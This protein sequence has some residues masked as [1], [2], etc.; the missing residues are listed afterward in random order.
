[1]NRI[2]EIKKERARLMRYLQKSQQAIN[3]NLKK[4][5]QLQRE[6]EILLNPCLPGI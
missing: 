4:L 1:M 3:K 2:E 6:E 5:K